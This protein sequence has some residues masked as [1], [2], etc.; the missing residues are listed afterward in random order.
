[1]AEAGIAGAEIIQCDIDPGVLEPL[2]HHR[3][4][5]AVRD[6]GAFRHF[7]LKAVSRKARFLQGIGDVAGDVIAFQIDGRKID[8]NTDAVAP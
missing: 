3:S 4:F 2:Q 6:D 8:R 1:M 7:H 5:V